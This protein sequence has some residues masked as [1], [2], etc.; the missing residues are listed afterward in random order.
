MEFQLILAIVSSFSNKIDK[1][2]II[3][4]ISVIIL[5]FIINIIINNC[6]CNKWLEGNRIQYLWHYLQQCYKLTSNLNKQ[7]ARLK[8]IFDLILSLCS[9]NCMARYHFV[10]KIAVVTEPLIFVITRL[11]FPKWPMGGAL[12]I[13]RGYRLFF[14]IL[15]LWAKMSDNLFCCFMHTKLQILVFSISKNI[16]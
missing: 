15:T 6:K 3:S 13:V 1:S 11:S 4:I 9:D 12:K 14:Y 2:I 5:Y 8:L 7:S 10:P 16:T